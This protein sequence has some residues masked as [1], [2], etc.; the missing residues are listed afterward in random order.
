MT[1]IVWLTAGVVAYGNAAGRFGR[2][3]EISKNLGIGPCQD[4]TIAGNHAYII[5]GKGLSVADIAAPGDPVVVGRL[6]GLGDV[7]QIAVQG[8]TAYITSRADGAFVVDISDPKALRLLCHYD[9]VELAT[10]VAVAGE[11]LVIANRDSGAELIDVSDPKNPV[12]LSTVRTWPGDVQS[13]CVHGNHLYMGVWGTLE[14]VAV[15]ISDPRKPVITAKA[16]LDGFGDGV[17]VQGNYIYVSTGHHDA[18]WR[19]WKGEKGLTTQVPGY[20]RGHGLEV[21][22]L[23]NPAV[24]KF[25]SRIKFR[26]FDRVWPD[27]WNAEVCGGYAFCADTYNGVFVVDVRDPRAPVCVAHR[28]LPFL[29]THKMCAPVGSLAVVDGYVYVAGWYTDLHVIAAPGL[30]SRPVSE[31][32]TPVKIPPQGKRQDS[33]GGEF[34]VYKPAGQVKAVGFLDDHVAV[35]AA[36]N[37]GIRVVK[38][39][40]EIEELGVYATGDI[41]H[42]VCVTGGFVYVAEGFH[43]LSIWG[44]RGKGEL[45]PRGRYAPEKAMVKQVSVPMP[46][47]YA[48]LQMGSQGVAIVDIA[49][50]DNPEQ[51]IDQQ[52]GLMYGDQLCLGLV[53]DRYVCAYGHDRGIFWFDLTAAPPVRAGNNPKTMIYGAGIVSLGSQILISKTGGYLLAS[54]DSQDLAKME[55]CHVGQGVSGKPSVYGNTLFLAN[56]KNGKVYIVDIADIHGP[57]LVRQLNTSGNPGRVVVHDRNLVIPDGYEGLL[58]APWANTRG[59][60]Q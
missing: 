11:L 59:V 5:G 50:P 53:E 13:V 56:R 2:E 16:A 20:A 44:Y 48:F 32:P 27:M 26:E 35:V 17:Y 8:T 37:A 42:D 45:V 60:R 52:V 9:S 40:P 28:Q 7:R 39:W 3:L 51:A 12:H 24:P 47:R 57:R 55:Y 23:T 25:V 34:R 38:L 49:D 36:G 1:A 4:V 31:S 46:G 15:D 6:S 54:Q 22:E 19:H 58:V 43:G 18:Q 14:L 33:R 21:F 30:A 29:E 41:A 10:G